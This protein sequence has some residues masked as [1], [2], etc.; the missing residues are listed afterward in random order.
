MFK[1]QII[2]SEKRTKKAVEL[3]IELQ[4]VASKHGFTPKIH[5]TE[6][7]GILFLIMSRDN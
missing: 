4:Q 1:K 6:F 2:Y 3:E 7:S 5:E